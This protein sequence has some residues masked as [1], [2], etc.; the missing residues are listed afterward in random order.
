MAPPFSSEELDGGAGQALNDPAT[1]SRLLAM[2]LRCVGS[3]RPT[4]LRLFSSVCFPR[5]A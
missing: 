4:R 1:R 5:L 3:R 2:S